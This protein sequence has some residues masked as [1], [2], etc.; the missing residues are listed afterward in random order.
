MRYG[1]GNFY[2]YKL[3]YLVI[4]EFFFVQGIYW[5]YITEHVNF[6]EILRDI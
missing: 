1:M 5:T 6:G 4:N 2:S 3:Q